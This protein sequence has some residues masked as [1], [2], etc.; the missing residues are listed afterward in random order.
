MKAQPG[1]NTWSQPGKRWSRLATILFLSVT[2]MTLGQPTGSAASR[3][4]TRGLAYKYDRNATDGNVT[5]NY[6][7]PHE[8]IVVGKPIS[9]CT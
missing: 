7:T 3:L 8:E 4:S 2:A 9:K 6:M 1:D 5:V